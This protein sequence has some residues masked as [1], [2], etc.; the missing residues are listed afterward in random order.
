MAKLI[1]F[2]TK[3]KFHSCVPAAAEFVENVAEGLR[4]DKARLEVNHEVGN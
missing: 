4:A 3:T 1:E 2:L